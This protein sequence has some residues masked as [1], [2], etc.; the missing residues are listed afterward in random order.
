MGNPSRDS[1]PPRLIRYPNR[2]RTVVP[3]RF[4]EEE[5]KSEG[6]SGAIDIERKAPKA[7]QWKYGGREDGGRLFLPPISIFLSLG[8]LFSLEDA[9]NGS[10]YEP[11]AYLFR[12]STRNIGRTPSSLPHPA[13]PFRPVAIHPWRRGESL[14]RAR[15]GKRIFPP[16]VA[17]FSFLS[18]TK[19]G[20]LFAPADS[21]QSIVK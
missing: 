14:P 18:A 11:R 1:I 5:D 19:K 12:R 15:E 17:F 7:R 21:L 4:A 20:R 8:A 13:A 3:R 9:M 6:E 16:S 10:F 2:M